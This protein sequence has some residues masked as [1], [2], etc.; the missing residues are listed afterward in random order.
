M[1]F[2]IQSKL[3][4]TALLLSLSTIAIAQDELKQWHTKDA[5]E[6]YYGVSSEKALGLLTG[7]KPTKVRV[8]II[9]SGVDVEHEDLKANIWVNK[10]EIPG[11]GI[12]DDGNGYVDDIHGWNF[13]GNAAG[14]NLIHANLEM[15]RI[16]RKL[17]PR[18]A[19]IENAKAVSKEDKVDYALFTEVKSQI[20][21][22]RAEAQAQFVQLEAFVTIFNKAD[23]VAT[24]ALGAGYTLEALMAWNAQESEQMFKGILAGVLADPNF[25]KKEL[26]KYYEYFNHQLLYHYNPQYDDRAVI[27][28]D[29]LKTSE[30]F[31]GNGQ[32]W[33]EQADHGTHVSGI[34]GAVKGNGKGMDGIAPD[35]ELMVLRAV[36][37]GDE[38]DKDIANAIRYAADNGAQIINMSFGKGYSPSTEAVHAAIRHAEEK[39]VL[40]VHAAGN[41]ANNLDRTP[42]FPHPRYGFQKNPCA[43]WL[44]VGA[45]THTGD[46]KFIAVFSNYGKKQ[47]DLF[48]P[49]ARIWSTK[50]GNV[51][52]FEDGTS[53]AA[54]VVS[55]V[56]A[57]IKSYFPG[58]TAVQLR[59]LLIAT[60]RTYP[61][62]K[63][64]TPDPSYNPTKLVGM[65]KISATG[66][67]VNAF[68]AVERALK[69]Y[70]QQ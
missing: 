5:A 66:G 41:D 42:N 48:A 67:V 3:F 34:V 55:G 37:N 43:T 1:T 13:M 26:E 12:D 6:G 35:V 8:A 23:S 59:D 14:V 25:N 17:A 63:V 45:T 47:V 36:P 21:E 64:L 61:K 53:M 60:S 68:D 65:N 62:L 30:Q 32:V 19:Q 22:K 44:T 27:G 29:Y 10:G 9:D 24:A 40:M 16:Y 31:Y 51:Y 54:P 4:V 69:L 70:P 33:I 28:D 56:A 39:G 46:D 50:P 20:E 49:G 2:R 52:E 11:N 18:F 38:F 15:T 7:R 58:I 57:L